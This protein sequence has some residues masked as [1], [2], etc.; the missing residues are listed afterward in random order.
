MKHVMLDIETLGMPPKGALLQIGACMFDPYR[1]QDTE[2][3]VVDSFLVSVRRGYYDGMR[4]DTW[5]V[6]PRTVQ[7]WGEQ[8][9][10]AQEGLM[11]NLVSSPREALVRFS[12]WLTANDFTREAKNSQDVAQVWANP[13][14]FDL[15]ILN[16]AFDACDLK[17]PWHYRQE[18]D[19]RTLMWLGQNIPN[20]GQG[21]TELLN[22]LVPHRG[23]HD[24]IRQ[25]LYVQRALARMARLNGGLTV[26]DHARAS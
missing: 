25:A 26:F 14:T 22:G 12:E 6:E 8:S 1:A 24:A 15:A 9:E 7:W 23:D 5:A 11:L 19:A 2:E 21:F 3:L 18:K 10:E 13:P 16:Y 17:R 20:M 4:D